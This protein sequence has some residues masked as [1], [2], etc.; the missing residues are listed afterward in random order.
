MSDDVEPV[1]KIKRRI[2]RGIWFD[3]AAEA[4]VTERELV[5]L[6]Q[7]RNGHLTVLTTWNGE[8]LRFRNVEE[9]PW[10]DPETAEWALFAALDGIP[11]LADDRYSFYST[12]IV[13]IED[14]ASGAVLFTRRSATNEFEYDSAA[15]PQGALFVAAD[16]P[17]LIYPSLR[18]AERALE[19]IDVE[20]GVY[21]AAYG[22]NGEPYGIGT[23]GQR[24]VIERTGQS[25]KPDELKALLLRYLHANGSA[26]SETTSLGALTTEVWRIESAFWREHDPYRERPG[27]RIPSWGRMAIV[28]GFAVFLYLVFL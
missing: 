21:P 22:P 5:A 18:A 1:T 27:S 12:E 7:S 15:V 3:D 14:G 23:D 9:A 24:V 16:E 4:L 2:P 8:A 10:L 26:P 28:A 13:L 20:N 6:L 11:L 25:D 17:L 19:A